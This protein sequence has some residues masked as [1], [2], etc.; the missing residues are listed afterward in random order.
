M[1]VLGTQDEHLPEVWELDVGVRCP[2]ACLALTKAQHGSS[3]L[4]TPAE[5][6]ASWHLCPP[7]SCHGEEGAVRS[8][9]WQQTNNK[10]HFSETPRTQHRRLE[11]ANAACQGSGAGYL[12]LFFKVNCFRSVHLLEEESV[13]KEHVAYS[14]PKTKK[15]KKKALVHWSCLN[16]LFQG[17]S[18]LRGQDQ[19]LGHPGAEVQTAWVTK[20]EHRIWGSLMAPGLTGS[21]WLSSFTTVTVQRV[22]TLRGFTQRRSLSQSSR[23]SQSGKGIAGFSVPSSDEGCGWVEFPP[24]LLWQWQSLVPCCC[25][26]GVLVSLLVLEWKA[27]IAPPTPSVTCLLHLRGQ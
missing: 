23:S 21:L 7:H 17:L 13:E 9:H 3:A 11:N 4:P 16:A 14:K 1:E 12:F 26:F 27:P 24:E 22:T 5:P 25:R 20:S 6:S 19:H 18:V 8:S 2:Q 15:D 10:I